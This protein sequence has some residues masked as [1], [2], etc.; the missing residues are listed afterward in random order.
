MI[1]NFKTCVVLGMAPDGK[2]SL[3]TQTDDAAEAVQKTVTSEYMQVTAAW[4]LDTRGG[5]RLLKRFVN[6]NPK[7]KPGRPP[8]VKEESE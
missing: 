2:V 4:K 3:I 8:K 1:T 6:A 5:D 7:R